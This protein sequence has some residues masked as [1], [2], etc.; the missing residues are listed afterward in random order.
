MPQYRET[1]RWEGR[2]G[3]VGEYPHRDRGGEM[4]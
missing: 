3:W 4:G 1:P 2:S